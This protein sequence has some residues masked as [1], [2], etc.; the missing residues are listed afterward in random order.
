MVLLLEFLIF[1]FFFPEVLGVFS[2]L[3]EKL[4]ICLYCLSSVSVG[5]FLGMPL[6]YL[7][8]HSCIS[9]RLEANLIGWVNAFSL[10]YVLFL[11]F[12]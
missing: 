7:L 1:K 9:F 5:G 3:I 10:L 6:L 4:L 11:H 2:V 8:L 12:I